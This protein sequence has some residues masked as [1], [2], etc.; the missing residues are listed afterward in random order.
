VNTG[1]LEPTTE[2]ESG[3]RK[4]AAE[5]VIHNAAAEIPRAG[6]SSLPSSRLGTLLDASPSQDR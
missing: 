1:H 6:F 3:P 4:L 2:I 5:D